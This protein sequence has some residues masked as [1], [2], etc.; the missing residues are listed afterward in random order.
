MM[1]APSH[2]FGAENEDFTAPKFGGGDGTG[3]LT[4]QA[5][6]LVYSWSGQTGLSAII[7]SA[8]WQHY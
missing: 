5:N 3:R 1:S 6:M 8:I 7:S 2:R 4:I